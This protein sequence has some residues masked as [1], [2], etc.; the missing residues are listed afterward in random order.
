MG[1]KKENSPEYESAVELSEKLCKIQDEV[2]IIDRAIADLQVSKAKKEMD[3]FRT[4]PFFKKWVSIVKREKSTEFFAEPNHY[5]D[6]GRRISIS[7][8]E[9]VMLRAFKQGRIDEINEE[10]RKLSERINEE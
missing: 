7:E 1:K 5:Y 10:I 6:N 2:R 3:G 9:F 8:A 4:N